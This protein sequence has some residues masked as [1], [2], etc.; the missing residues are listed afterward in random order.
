MINIH[1]KSEFLEFI[2]LTGKE[3]WKIFHESKDEKEFIKNLWIEEC[4]EQLDLTTEQFFNFREEILNM[5]HKQY[6][7]LKEKDKFFTQ[8]ANESMMRVKKLSSYSH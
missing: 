7:L 2:G 6:K 8:I 1:I 5:A 3:L 4:I